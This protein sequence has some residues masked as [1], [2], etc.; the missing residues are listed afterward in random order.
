MFTQ[1]NLSS[2]G[3]FSNLAP[4]TMS[5]ETTLSPP[6]A[7]ITLMPR[8]TFAAKFCAHYHITMEHYEDTVL[9]LGLYPLARHLQTFLGLFSNYFVP[10]RDFV[11]GVGRSLHL[12]DFER[13][14]QEFVHDPANRGFLRNSLNLRISTRRMRR[15]AGE[16]L[17]DQPPCDE[18][19]PSPAPGAADQSRAR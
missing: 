4:D 19:E 13:E 5:N 1:K 2:A 16:L 18:S 11:R 3:T 17:S 12:Y 9:E 15:I 10:D 6:S 7:A 8:G 14:V